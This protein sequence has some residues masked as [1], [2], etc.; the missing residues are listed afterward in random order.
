MIYYIYK[1]AKCCILPNDFWQSTS[2][3]EASWQKVVSYLFWSVSRHPVLAP[4]GQLL[5]FLFWSE[6]PHPVFLGKLKSLTCC[7]LTAHIQNWGQL[8]RCGI[9]PPVLG[10]AGKVWSLTCCG[11]TLH[12]QCLGQLTRC[13]LWASRGAKTHL[14]V[15]RITYPEKEDVNNN[16]SQTLDFPCP[17]S[18][19]KDWR[20]LDIIYIF[21]VLSLSV[22]LYEWKTGQ[23]LMLLWPLDMSTS[24]QIFLGREHILYIPGAY[25]GHIIRCIWDRY[26]T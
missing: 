1:L 14:R 11:L 5:S 16:I 10:T 18:P 15:G 6:F 2:S 26:G 8:L 9:L 23:T 4:A 3:V 21:L 17:F 12:I 22:W 20:N 19:A 13:G 7:G 24:F 25:L